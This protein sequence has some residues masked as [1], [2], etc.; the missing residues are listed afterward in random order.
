M[1]KGVRRRQ[2][3]ASVLQQGNFASQA[4]LCDMLKSHGIS[5]TQATVSRD[6]R[7]LGAVK[8]PTGYRLFAS[9]KNAIPGTTLEGRT[10]RLALET[11]VISAKPAGNLVV[12]RTGVGQ[13]QVVA[14]ELDRHPQEGVIGVIAGDDTIFIALTSPRQAARLAKSVCDVA[15]IGRPGSKA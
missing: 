14:V 10:F 15:D 12:L 5:A 4:E 3:I 6:L 8:G 13:A 9:D 11:Y 2:L 7:E 1:G